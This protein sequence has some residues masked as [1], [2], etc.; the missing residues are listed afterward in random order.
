MIVKMKKISLVVL[1]SRIQES[2]D[3]LRELGVVHL[4]TGSELNEKL[5]ELQAKK[6]LL[7][8]AVSLLPESEESVAQDKITGLGAALEA[9]G[10]IDEEYQKHFTLTDEI[11]HIERDIDRLSSWGDFDPD[12]IDQLRERGI[13]IRLYEVTKE[14]LA[15]FPENVKTFTIEKSKVTTKLAAV[16]TDGFEELPFDE[17]SL[18][19]KPLSKLHQELKNKNQELEIID[20]DIKAF[21][22]K[23]DLLTSGLQQ[24]DELIEF[25][26]AVNS[27]NNEERISFITGFAPGRLDNKIKKTAAD[28][29]WG[30]MISEPTDEDNVP[31]LVENPKWINA[32][33]PVFGLLGTIPGYK[34]FDISIWFLLF[35]S[36]FWAM[37]LGDAGYGLI[38]LGIT[39]FSRIKFRKAPF[40]PFLLL[41]VTSITTI[42]WGGMSGNWF[43]VESFAAHPAVSWMLVPQIAS[44][45]SL[46]DGNVD[47]FIMHICFIIGAV[48]LSVAH[49]L[50]LARLF[51]SL[52]A[53]AEIGWLGVL[54]G[55]YLLIR[56]LVLKFPSHPYA[57]HILLGGLGAVI[58]FSEQEGNFFKGIINGLS[59]L[60]LISLGSI[61]FF[62]DIV[63]Y[64]RLF[65]V[66]LATL[67]VAK[68]FNAMA[69]GLGSGAVA[70]LG[71]AFIL[72]FG[73][74]LNIILGCMSLIV[75]GVRLN[76]LEF[77]GHLS[78]EWSGFAYK[79][80]KR[81]K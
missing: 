9:A 13:D 25:E 62:S 17:I 61:G 46:A 11:H 55:L 47:K 59:N 41:F 2:L 6:S 7:T 65:A 76:M 67:E 63:S 70:I 42:A 33:K 49:L 32:I 20:N 3:T 54:W 81:A 75:H 10:K 73:H 77:S 74:G 64:V 37:I 8:K 57:L 68:S 19:E 27:M 79:P 1:T 53:Y 43:G 45:K 16:F 38:F 66:G 29:G 34:E 30:V 69:A 22:D 23:R 48:H 28:N 14:Q 4:E 80:F 26:T 40:E 56:A 78:M 44:F 12:E 58:I 15:Q 52:K 24:L 31:T 39:I 72:F 51:P 21:A 5:N 60:I 71:S 36:V 35:F 50:N 18:P